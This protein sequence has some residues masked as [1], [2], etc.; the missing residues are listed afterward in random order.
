M[1]LWGKC[2]NS[3]LT[4][5]SPPSL[6]HLA[7]ARLSERAGEH[8]REVAE[9]RTGGQHP[10]TA[11]PRAV[12]RQSRVAFISVERTDGRSCASVTDSGRTKWADGR[13]GRAGGRRWEGMTPSGTTT[14]PAHQARRVMQGFATLLR[15]S[16]RAHSN[17]SAER[18]LIKLR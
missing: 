3:S 17:I 15:Q 4:R 2:F 13:M 14:A 7:L 5:S 16:S 6:P 8:R 18:K 9:G 10:Q 12:R 11:L 1:L